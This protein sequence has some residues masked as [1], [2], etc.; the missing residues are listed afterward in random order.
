L[1]LLLFSNAQYITTDNRFKYGL[2]PPMMKWFA[3]LFQ[4]YYIDS[5]FE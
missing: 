5:L 4:I 1:L 2:F 3:T